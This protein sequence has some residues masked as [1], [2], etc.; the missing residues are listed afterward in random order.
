[1]YKRA[2]FLPQ[3][4]LGLLAVMLTA[5]PHQPRLDC[6]ERLWLLR[7]IDIGSTLGK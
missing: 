6:W 5:V 2:H 7:Y 4:A 3:V 1:M